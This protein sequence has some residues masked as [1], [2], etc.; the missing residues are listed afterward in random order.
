MNNKKIINAVKVFLSLL[1]ILWII[2]VYVLSS[3]SG[4]ESRELK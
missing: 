4:D 1:M 3:Q 2:A